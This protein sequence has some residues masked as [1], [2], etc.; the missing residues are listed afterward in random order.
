MR[1]KEMMKNQKIEM[2][3]KKAVAALASIWAAISPDTSQDGR[4]LDQSSK[5][6]EL[7]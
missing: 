7:R 4:G 1:A 3:G 2:D 5:S 6:C